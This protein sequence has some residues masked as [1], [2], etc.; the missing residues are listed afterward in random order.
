MQAPSLNLMERPE[1]KPQAGRAEHERQ[2]WERA[3]GREVSREQAAEY[4]QRVL[5]CIKVLVRIE[6]ESIE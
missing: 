4:S 6:R 2:T 5:C 3:L 1:R